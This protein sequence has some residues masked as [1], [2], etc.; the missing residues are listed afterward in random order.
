MKAKWKNKKFKKSQH[1]LLTFFFLRNIIVAEFGT[2]S[3][4]VLALLNKMIAIWE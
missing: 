3:L 1:K 4:E 2:L